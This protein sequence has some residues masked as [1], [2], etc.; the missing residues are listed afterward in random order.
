MASAR[1]SADRNAIVSKSRSSGGNC[2]FAETIDQAIAA[3]VKAA[4]PMGKM[5][6]YERQAVLNHC[7]RRFEERAAELGDV[8][9]GVF[10]NNLGDSVGGT[11]PFTNELS[12]YTNQAKEFQ[13]PDTHKGEVSRSDT[14]AGAGFSTNN[15]R[16]W[17]PVMDN[18]GRGAGTHRAWPEFSGGP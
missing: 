15:H 13:A 8:V 1:Q 14:G 11:Q 6:P 5:A 3:A 9:E 10:K 4:G 16:S 18:T 7:V 12:Q 2:L 17:H